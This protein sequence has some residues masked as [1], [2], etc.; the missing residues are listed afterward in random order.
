[1]SLAQGPS[2]S[3]PAQRVEQVVGQ[4][5]A[6]EEFRAPDQ[7]SALGAFGEWLAGLFEHLPGASEGSGLAGPVALAVGTVLAL[8]FAIAL[9]RVLVARADERHDERPAPQLGR[10]RSERPE[11]V[12]EASDW[13]RSAERA[14]ATGDLRQA[15]SHYFT[16]LVVGLGAA[17]QLD[18]DQAWTNRELL[19]HG[20]PARPW[21]SRLAGLVERN[22]AKSFG[23]LATSR[24]DVDEL[25]ELCA[26]V[27][28]SPG[29]PS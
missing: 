15:L 18:Y 14:L 10:A 21:D 4:V 3:I 2:A 29:V 23:A 26:G 13:L 8:V 22:E 1:M 28:P 16:A 19:V 5:L 25:R 9:R 12:R 27:L 6:R 24:A 7:Q 17:G 11:L 20:R